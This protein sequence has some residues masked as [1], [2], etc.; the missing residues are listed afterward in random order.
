MITP[1]AK[2]MEGGK[3]HRGT[4][5]PRNMYWLKNGSEIPLAG[6]KSAV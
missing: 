1:M 4:A 3:E 6:G 2:T 5:T